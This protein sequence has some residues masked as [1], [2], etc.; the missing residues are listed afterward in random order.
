[1]PEK[2]A[3]SSKGKSSPSQ[4][5]EKEAKKPPAAPKPTAAAELNPAPELE[6]PVVTM[7]STAEL[8]KKI[9]SKYHDYL[10]SVVNNPIRQF[11]GGTID[12]YLKLIDEIGLPRAVAKAMDSRDYS[13]GNS[14]E[15]AN[16]NIM[17]AI[18]PQSRVLNDVLKEAVSDGCMNAVKWYPEASGNP[19]EIIEVLRP[20]LKDKENKNRWWAAVHLSRHVQEDDGLVDVLIEAL[21]S[22][23]VAYKIDNSS[24][25]MSGKGEAAKALARLGKKAEAAKKD[26]YAQLNS[27]QIESA[28]A[29]Q[30]AGALLSI[31]GELDQIMA[32]LAKLAER[33]LNERRGL[34]LHAGDRE[35]LT[36]VRNLIAKWKQAE[37]NKSEEMNAKVEL[38]EKE[39]KYHLSL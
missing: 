24:A 16:M 31:T 11:Q 10:T 14:W 34:D 28:D 1:M 38:L 5:K 35:L 2:K 22:N 17:N 6:S 29:A 13:R 33:V 19:K 30:I 32:Q 27:E 7:E 12:D 21:N 3:K 8:F 23:W 15:Q 20:V 37:G 39:I 25:G 36:T 26:L 4:K 18:L 9:D